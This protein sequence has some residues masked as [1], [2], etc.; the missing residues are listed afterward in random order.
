MK[1]A[2]LSI[3]GGMD[4]TSLLVHLLANSYE[5]RTFSFD[6][7]QRHKVE[8]ERLQQNIQYLQLLNFPVEWSVIDLKSAFNDSTS[9]LLP[10][11]G[12]E[13][14]IG[15]YEDE[16][17]KGTVVENRNTIFSAVLYGKALAWANKTKENVEICLG[18]HSG[19]HLIYPDCRPEFHKAI[20]YAFKIG[21][22]GS[23]RVSNYLPYLEGDKYSILKDCLIN[24]SNLGLDFETILRNTNTC[25]QPNEN[26]ESCGI[27][28]SCSERLEAFEKLEIK[29]P[30]QYIS[31]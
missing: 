28:G 13:V 23:E 7:G 2:V 5:V 15:H 24:C 9:S 14:P 18:T 20:D 6:Y 19:D 26:G 3:S 8:L 27:C 25:Y 30:V 1:K 29:D 16:T 11:S 10:Q 31:R 21:N 4:S 12:V 17:M 22:W